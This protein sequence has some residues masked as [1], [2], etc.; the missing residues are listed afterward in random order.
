L[1]ALVPLDD[2]HF[3]LA[4]GS[5]QRAG[6]AEDPC[7]YDCKVKLVTQVVDHSSSVVALQFIAR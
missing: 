3:E 7:T 5:G 6:K 1:G 4:S 2:N